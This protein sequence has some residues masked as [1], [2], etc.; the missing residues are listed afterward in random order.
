MSR[1]SLSS[2]LALLGSWVMTPPLPPGETP[3]PTEEA[4]NQVT[5]T[6]STETTGPPTV[7][8]RKDTRV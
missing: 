4:T 8:G 2:I 3:F 6:V 5:E 1:A 7:A